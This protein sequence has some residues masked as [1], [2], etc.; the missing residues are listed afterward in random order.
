LPIAE[1]LSYG[2]VC[3]ASNATSI[4]EAGGS[5]ADYFDPYDEDA[6]LSL[7]LKY[8]DEEE[9]T[10]REREIKQAYK[11]RD[12][13]ATLKQ[14]FH[15]TAKINKNTPP[16]E[17]KE[18]EMYDGVVI[19]CASLGQNCGIASYSLYVVDAIR[20][21]GRECVIIDD[22]SS[23]FAILNTGKFLHVI[24]QHEY[25]LYDDLIPHLGQGEATGTLIKNLSYCKSTYSDITISFVMHTIDSSNPLLIQRNN[26]IFNSD[27]DVYT[28]NSNGARKFNLNYLE[29]GVPSG[30]QFLNLS[31]KISSVKKKTT[32][33]WFGFVSSMK[34][35]DKLL[36]DVARLNCEI[37]A[38]FATEEQSV[39]D[40][41]RS[42]ISIL[43][44]KGTVTFGFASDRSILDMLA[45]CDFCYFPQADIGY[46]ATSG[47]VRLAMLSET[48]VLVS[49]HE[50]F[51]DLARGI[52][53]VEDEDLEVCIEQLRE[54]AVYNATV[55]RQCAFVRSNTIEIVYNN[56]LSGKKFVP[57]LHK[58]ICVRQFLMLPKD[59]FI[60]IIS[61]LVSNELSY[62]STGGA[63]DAEL[64]TRIKILKEVFC[65]EDSLTGD[66]NSVYF[67]YFSDPLP[68]LEFSSVDQIYLS[69]L[70]A[71]V[72][73]YISIHLYRS[74][75]GRNPTLD[76]HKAV[77]RLWT[78]DPLACVYWLAQDLHYKGNIC[79]NHSSELLGKVNE[80]C[81]LQRAISDAGITGDNLA[82]YERTRLR[83][84]FPDFLLP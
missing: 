42:Q 60:K 65:E 66:N 9:R 48:P 33:G 74:M 57:V 17:L 46:H 10:F 71:L 12:W 50:Q 80:I 16:P 41:I 28:L 30:H 3:L 81:N 31:E 83:R 7:V 35:I 61:P 32:I 8:L 49:P 79:D 40:D 15:A 43:G 37:F 44:L 24:V 62:I 64:S 70:F 13:S 59:V 20:E 36:I 6:F 14:I 58:L 11:R 76:E 73:D 51:L 34:R 56:M 54:R 82:A 4:P 18:M 47:S 39:I 1:A 23:L 75:A 27:I 53:F 67:L 26:I 68:S 22:S 69:D 21:A 38:N 72:D 5:L 19:I 29:H 84:E 77:H 78:L 45:R 25:G 2:K 55:K 63:E 52:I